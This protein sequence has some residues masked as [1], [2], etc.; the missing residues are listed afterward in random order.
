MI[1]QDLNSCSHATLPWDYSHRLLLRN[2]YTEWLYHFHVSYLILHCSIHF[3]VSHFTEQSITLSCHTAAHKCG[4]N[5][6]ALWGHRSA[7][8]NWITLTNHVFSRV[9]LFR[10]FPKHWTPSGENSLISTC[11]MSRG[12]MWTSQSGTKMLARRTTSWEG[13]GTLQSNLRQALYPEITHDS[14][15]LASI[16]FVSN[17]AGLVLK[18]CTIWGLFGSLGI[19]LFWK[20]DLLIFNLLQHRIL[21]V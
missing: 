16:K 1:R 5:V 6:C 8:N 19:I 17:S 9:V 3:F 7:K 2:T 12:A 20:T 11:M 18:C 10:Q 15:F 21:Y 14:Y 4:L 13:M